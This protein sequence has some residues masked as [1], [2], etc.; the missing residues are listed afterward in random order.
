MNYFRPLITRWNDGLRGKS[1]PRRVTAPDG[2]PRWQAATGRS[3]ETHE[4]ARNA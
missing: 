3:F 2:S 4:E 1:F